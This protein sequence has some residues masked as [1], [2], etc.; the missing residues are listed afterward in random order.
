MPQEQT[1]AQS[2]SQERLVSESNGGET[3]ASRA[4]TGT[5]PLPSIVGRDRRAVSE[6]P[7]PIPS[8]RQKDLEAV[9]S[10]VVQVSVVS[11][12]RITN[13]LTLLAR[14]YFN[15][16]D[17][18]CCRGDLCSLGRRCSGEEKFRLPKPCTDSARAGAGRI[19]GEIS[20]SPIRR[21]TARGS[22]RGKSTKCTVEVA[23]WCYE[24]RGS[25]RGGAGGGRGYS[26]IWRSG[27][28]LERYFCTET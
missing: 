28:G 5:A 24:L 1:Q 7:L 27:L 10:A 16:L 3:S 2:Q 8:D 11:T 13:V 14:D 18:R 6:A 21:N 15:C 9:P 22:E 26:K 23:A 4:P 25:E 19:R 17:E 12:N 20:N